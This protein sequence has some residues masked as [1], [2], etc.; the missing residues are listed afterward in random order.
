[1][2][3]IEISHEHKRCRSTDQSYSE[4]TDEIR[5]HRAFDVETGP[6]VVV[7]CHFNPCG[8]KLPIRNLKLILDALLCARVPVYA[9]EL[10]CGV[11]LN[12]EPILPQTHPHVLQMRSECVMWQKESLW[13]HVV[14]RLPV[15][16][17]KVLCL[18]ADIILKYRHWPSAISEALDCVP[19]LQPY[20]RAVWLDPMGGE[21]SNRLSAGY[22]VANGL[23]D[24]EDPR[25]YHPGFG[26]A[27]RRDLWETVGGLYN[28]PMGNGDWMLI[29]AALGKIDALRPSVEGMSGGW[30]HHYSRWA[31][32]IHK[33]CSGIVDCIPSD[34]QHLW[35]GSKKNRQYLDRVS[36]LA[37]LDPYSDIE[38]DT[39]TGLP[40]WSSSA[41]RLKQDM[42]LSV[43]AYFK[44]R[45]EDDFE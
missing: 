4:L 31:L 20:S 24:P 44:V 28:A 38:I 26:I 8:Y 6:I 19:L 14:A 16:F 25:I 3:E 35:H 12:A 33:W 39:V 30:W 11:Q 17:R 37:G 45:R 22:A 2:R 23:T 27:A 9:A 7:L 18:D 32:A 42:V 40:T 29:A 1:M 34:A 5:K 13:N 15:Q 36:R 10:R 21:R 41:Q 43:E